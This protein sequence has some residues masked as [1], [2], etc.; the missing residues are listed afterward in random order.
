MTGDHVHTQQH[1]VAQV[2]HHLEEVPSREQQHEHLEV[3]SL[4]L[5]LLSLGLPAPP[6]TWVDDIA[7]PVVATECST[8]ESALVQIAEVVV[9]VCRRHGLVINFGQHKTEAVVS[10]RSRDAP[11]HRAALLV[12]R[13]GLL[14]LPQLHRSLRCVAAYEHLGTI[15]AG[16]NTLHQEVAH[17]R[18]KAL[19]AYRQIGKSILRNRHVDVQVRLK[20]FEALIIPIL[21]HGAGNWGVLSKRSFQSLHSSIM[22]WQRSIVNDGFWAADQHTDLELQ[23]HWKLPSLALRLIK[24][25]LLYA[26]HCLCEGPGLLIDY[27]TAD[28]HLPG[29]WFVALRQ[30]LCWTAR[31]D[32]TFCPPELAAASPTVIIQWFTDH[33]QHGAS[34][35]RSLYRKDLL[36]AHVL[37]DA[38][39]LHKQLRN[40][41]HRAGVVFENTTA[42]FSTSPDDPFACDWCGHAFD[43]RQKLQVHLWTA[44]QMISD[45]RRFV[46]SDTCLA[47][48]QCLWTAARMQQHLR[49]SRRSADG[50]YA[51]LT[52][53]Y[54]PLLTSQAVDVPEDLRGHARLP[55]TLVPLPSASPV[56]Q[57]IPT[58]AAADAVLR[59]AWNSH[60]LPHDLPASIRDEACRFADDQVTQWRPQGCLQTDELLFRLATFIDND[61][62]KLWALC[63]W[64]QTSLVF[65]RFAHLTPPVFQRLKRDIEDLV[66]A[67]PLGGLLAWLRRMDQAHMPRSDDLAP[68]ARQH[69]LDFECVLDSVKQQHEG[70]A[71][72]VQPVLTLPDCARVP[73]VME[74]GQPTIWILHLFSG[75]RRRGDCHFWVDCMADFIPGYR[76]RILSVDTA[77]HAVRGNLDRGPIFTMLLR[78]INKRFFASGLTGPPCETFSAARHLVL[79]GERHP[80]PLRSAD[81]PWLLEH[82]SCRELYQTMIGTRL[83][84]HSV[85]AETALVLVGAGSIMEHPREHP[86]D[87]RVSVWRTLFHRQWIRRLP[88]SHEHHIEQW[89]FGSSGVKPTTLRALNLGPPSLVADTLAAAAD[90]LAIRPCMPLRGRAED[91]SFR[92]AAA[93]EYP[94]NLCRSLVH[95]TLVGLRYRI[96]QFGH[97]TSSAL[98]SAED[99]WLSDLYRDASVIQH[100]S[101]FLP[102]FQG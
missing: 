97:V 87:D 101:T 75:R 55:A 72:L 63:L 47:C 3:P 11:R 82:R 24:A 5:G 83:L 67:T 90:P 86:D 58:R 39:A 66:C 89:R 73:I 81:Q 18:S 77:I 99:L 102:D 46:F 38:L 68:S 91:G 27:L 59:D 64:S 54:A 96:Q 25:R 13:M 49:L 85:I 28:A 4:Q 95:A 37:G 92:T 1:D 44:H 50:C 52:W 2:D 15:F 12:E 34:K 62:C 61:D 79:P 14:P 7:V 43:T 76:V 35:I 69:D 53:R 74:D 65:S 29:G 84:F 71:M 48:G 33:R 31:M 88:D 51:Q 41:M 45:E 40:T 42:C 60:D 100:R 94:S 23:R 98:S 20:L 32:P 93:K 36:Q 6:V 22:T 9:S 8:L 57:S 10:F 21:L 30:A 70:V 56:E 80:R 19:H 16:D 17:R 26:F 78:I